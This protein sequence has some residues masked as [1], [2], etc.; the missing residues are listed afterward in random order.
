MFTKLSKTFCC[1]QVST[2]Y[3]PWHNGESKCHSPT[4]TNDHM[5][6]DKKSK[7]L[8][9]LVKN[10]SCKSSWE[11]NFFVF[12]DSASSFRLKLKVVLELTSLKPNLNKEKELCKC[13]YGVSVFTPSIRCY[14]F[15]TFSSHQFIPRY[16]E[17]L[18]G[19]F[20]S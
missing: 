9:H 5:I 19:S 15:I 16:D 8:E 2:G 1:K 3:Q 10:L 12:L 17:I 4:S 20:F 18:I 13:H 6:T 14:V 11:K 7:N